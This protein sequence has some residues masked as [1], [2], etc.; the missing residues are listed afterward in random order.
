MDGHRS[1]ERDL[2]QFN[3]RGKDQADDRGDAPWPCPSLESRYRS[4]REL[5]NRDADNGPVGQFGFRATI[6]EGSSWRRDSA[7]RVELSRVWRPA[8]SRNRRALNG[9]IAI[10]SD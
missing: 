6:R 7:D 8:A 3:L 2:R 10:H 1:D 9:R 5:R 4:E